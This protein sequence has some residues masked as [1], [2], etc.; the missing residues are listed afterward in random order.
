MILHV[1]SFKNGKTLTFQKKERMEF[2]KVKT[3]WC[4]VTD[5]KNG[6]M[7]SFKVDEIATVATM[8]VDESVKKPGF[9]AVI[10]K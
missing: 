7:L 4:N 1:L 10:N 6:Q 8:E 2:A 5:D 3:I 9:N